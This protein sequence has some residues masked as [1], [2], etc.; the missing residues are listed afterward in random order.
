MNFFW[1][2][3]WKNFLLYFKNNR[4][5]TLCQPSFLRNPLIT[6]GESRGTRHAG[7]GFGLTPPF[8]QRKFS[9]AYCCFYKIACMTCYVRKKLMREWR[10]TTIFLFSIYDDVEAITITSIF[11]QVNFLHFPDYSRTIIINWI[12]FYYVVWWW[13]ARQ[14]FQP[15]KKVRDTE[16]LHLLK[17]NSPQQN[18]FFPQFLNCEYKYHCFPHFFLVLFQLPFSYTCSLFLI[19]LSSFLSTFLY[20]IFVFFIKQIHSKNKYN[21]F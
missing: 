13:W 21:T 10:G 12:N 20:F 18:S 16:K 4:K 14:T 9:P 7:F 2:A 1:S 15:L 3:S 19:F 8:C 17:Y 11:F 5:G 6:G